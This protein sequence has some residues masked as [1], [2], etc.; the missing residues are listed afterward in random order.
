M[1]GDLDAANV[2]IDKLTALLLEQTEARKK[3]EEQ[4]LSQM[5][6]EEKVREMQDRLDAQV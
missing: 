1:S 4:I 6:M 2:E 3:M 5:E